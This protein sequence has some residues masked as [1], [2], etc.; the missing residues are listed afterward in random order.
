MLFP[1]VIA[2][3]SVTPPGHLGSA[4]QSLSCALTI[5]AIF[6]LWLKQKELGAVSHWKHNT[7]ESSRFTLVVLQA[8]SE[9]HS[10]PGTFGMSRIIWN[11]CYLFFPKQTGSDLLMMSM[12]W[13]WSLTVALATVTPPFIIF[14]SIL[15][16]LEEWRPPSVLPIQKN[17]LT[18]FSEVSQCPRMLIC[19]LH[20]FLNGIDGKAA[21][22]V[23]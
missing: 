19:F 22:Y 14:L 17:S 20:P 16:C 13:L 5:Y 12:C 15:C 1:T 21:R 9:L 8:R 4:R 2:L 18:V 23:S 11:P 6:L 7:T 3:S 10:I